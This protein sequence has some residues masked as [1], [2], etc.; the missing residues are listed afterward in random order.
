VLEPLPIQAQAP[1][2]RVER[3][4]SIARTGIGKDRLIQAL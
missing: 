1:A 2:I 3:V 4:S